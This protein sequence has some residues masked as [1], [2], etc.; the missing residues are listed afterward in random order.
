MSNDHLFEILQQSS[1]PIAIYAGPDY[2]IEMVNQAMLNIWGKDDSV[3]GK[4]VE[5]GISEMDGQPFKD[6]LDQVWSSGNTCRATE[7]A[8]SFESDGKQVIS[9]FDFCYQAIKDKEGTTFSILHTAVEVSRRDHTGQKESDQD[10]QQRHRDGVA[11]HEDISTLSDKLKD[12][13]IIF[14]ELISQAPVAIMLIQGADHLIAMANDTMLELIGR[15]QRIIGKPLFEEFPELV[16]QA[17]AHKLIATY[18]DGKRRTE[19]A[20]AV[21]LV[22]NGHM[23]QRYFNYNFA[24]YFEGGKVIGV[25]NIAME[26][27]DQVLTMRE[28]EER[29]AEKIKLEET[30][31]NSE[32]RLQGIL[33]TMAE[34]VGIID[35]DGQL[36]Y[37]N[38]M[39]QKILGLT[40]SEIRDRTFDDPRW[41]NLRLDGTPLPQEEH[42]MAM[43]M[44]T[45][46]P[47][48]DCE[49]GVQPPNRDRL[50]ISINAAPIFSDEGEL[51]GG[52]GTFMDVTS[53]RMTSQGK[54]DF[55]S[56]AS[57]ELKT[58][59]T[60]LKASLQLLERSHEQLSVER[61]EKLINKAISSLDNLSKLINGLLD[62]SR[63]EIGYE[64]PVDGVL[65][66]LELFENCQSQLE[67]SAVQRVIFSTEENL[68]FKGDTQELTQV[69]INFINNAIKYAPQSDQ[70]LVQ[71]G[72]AEG[73]LIKV[74]VEDAGPGIPEE[75]L[76]HLFERYYRTDYS[77]QQFSGLGLGLYISAEIIKRHGGTIGA[78][79]EIGKGSVF[80]FVLPQ[81]E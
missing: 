75:K 23:E 50:F 49:I 8:V 19:S 64:K 42:P 60:S 33:E 1:E 18:K 52:I 78:D 16:G 17:P 7:A 10:L 74:S 40:K 79:S 43:M 68:Q 54:D 20:S 22:K 69:L 24:P 6:L 31:R 53:R 30:L 76:V 70:I 51:T 71:A 28:R 46:K 58:P 26:V 57:H 55:I 67:N 66:T 25:I 35:R 61:R 45:G 47:V 27:T 48:F 72:R 2:K 38:P 39:A 41:Q 73:N 15:D 14:R 9:Y 34:G 56:I 59:V 77:G 4:T 37:A 5:Q 12:N 11:L 80:W 44:Q 13:E 65:S 81:V 32:Q 62:T 63:M 21:S 36:I 3:I 29:L